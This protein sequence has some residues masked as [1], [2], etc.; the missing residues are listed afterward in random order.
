MPNTKGIK[1]TMAFCIIVS[2]LFV[3]CFSK[4]ATGQEDPF[5]EIQQKLKGI[6][7][8]EREVL[9]TLFVLAQE[10]EEM[11]RREGEIVQEIKAIYQEIKNLED[12]IAVEEAAFERKRD[13]LKQVLK[14][15][16]RK[17][18]GSFLEILLESD[19][20]SV[21]LR[22]INTLRDLTRNTGE[23]LT[24]LEESKGKLAAEKVRV[25]E[26]ILFIEAKQL[27]LREALEK[28]EKL[29]ESQESY[30]ASLA[31]QRAYYLEYLTNLQKLFMELG[32]FFEIVAE[33]FAKV[34]E[35][36]NIPSHA[37]KTTITFMNITG[38]IDEKTFNDIIKANPRLPEM[39]FRFLPGK[40]EMSIPEKNL[41]LIGNFAI[42]EG[43]RIKFAVEAGTFL[44]MPLEA[45]ALEA[46]FQNTHLILDLKPLIG[47]NIL[48][49]IEILEG[50]L[51]LKVIPIIF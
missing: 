21:F 36:G 5:D 38:T 26:K 17:G 34:V 29:I 23:L 41:V 40:I 49:A 14:S 24:S 10:I 19:N 48:H 12:T 13:V 50:K 18:P 30:L 35:E 11:K 8:E 16:Q 15:Y 4:I 6:S 31:G 33:E 7:G 47:K 28:K 20:L 39:A 42:L 44:E 2:L 43:N 1:R 9:E 25:S 22:R 32:G 51:T 46:L 37:F 3:F 27:E 45:G